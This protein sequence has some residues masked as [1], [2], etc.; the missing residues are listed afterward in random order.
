MCKN[1]AS[2][3]VVGTRIGWHRVLVVRGGNRGRE[4]RAALNVGEG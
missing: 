1:S 2:N 4:V 3:T